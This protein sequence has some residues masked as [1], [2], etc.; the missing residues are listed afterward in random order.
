[1]ASIVGTR[2]ETI[3][4]VIHALGADGVT[5]FCGQRVVVP[6]LDMLLDEVES[7]EGVA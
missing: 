3:T 2:P 1:M 7:L 4:Q 5:Q 6:D